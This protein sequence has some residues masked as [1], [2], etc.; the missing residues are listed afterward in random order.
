MPIVPNKFFMTRGVGTHEKELRAFENALRDAGIQTCNL[1]KISSILP[2]G[3]KRV[4]REEGLKLLKA[5]Q[6]SFA[7]LAQASTNEPDQ[8]ISA[9]VG[10]A[11]PK[12]EKLYGYFTEVEEATGIAKEDV[13]H[14]AEEM[15]LE[16]LVTEWGHDFDAESVLE[17]WKK[18]YHLYNEDILVDSIVASAKGKPGNLYTV[19]VAVAVMLYE[20]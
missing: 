17:P 8:V 4:T 12:N 1:V 9:G 18:E 13:A 16:N 3:C 14:D 7:V 6:I 11:Q 5:G 20:E 15:A 10:L 2:P 19:V